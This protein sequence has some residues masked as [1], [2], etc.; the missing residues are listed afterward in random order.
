MNHVNELKFNLIEPEQP[1]AQNENHSTP[2]FKPKGKMLRVGQKITMQITAIDED[3]KLRHFHKEAVAGLLNKIQKQ[4]EKIERLGTLIDKLVSEQSGNN[5]DESSRIE[6]TRETLTPRVTQSP[7]IKVKRSRLSLLNEASKVSSNSAT[8][9]NAN[10]L[11]VQPTSTEL[12]PV[13]QQPNQD[14]ENDP[15]PF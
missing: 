4:K 13:N 14:E 8:S 1:T 3:S 11:P 7:V 5:L 12:E 10:H 2:L 9:P 15:C 6:N